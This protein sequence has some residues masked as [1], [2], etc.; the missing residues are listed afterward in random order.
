MVTELD[1]GFW[2]SLTIDEKGPVASR[3]FLPRQADDRT[4]AH[5]AAERPSRIGPI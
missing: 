1:I 5:P 2:K 3:H 4:P